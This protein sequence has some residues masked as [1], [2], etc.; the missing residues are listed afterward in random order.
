MKKLFVWPFQIYT[1]LFL[2]PYVALSTL[3]FGTLATILVFIIG[4]KRASFIGGVIWARLIGYLT[5]L[6]VKVVGRENV[7]PK[8]SY[9]IITNHQSIYDIIVLY[10]WLGL[11]FRWVMKM[12]LRKVPALGIAC[13]KIGHIF[14]DRS[15]SK[16]AVESINIAKKR[17]VN[18]TSVLFFPEGT[19]SLTGELRPFK[20]GAFNIAMDL[21]I[22][23]LPI[24]IVG[25]RNIIPSK[26]LFLT[27]GKVKMVFHEPID[28]SQYDATSIRKL[29]KKSKE[30]VG[31]ALN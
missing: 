10:G 20:K 13:E 7:D 14:I 15:N 23:I 3:F 4:P 30:V 2:V 27:P 25:T 19:R 16:K 21:D 28:T 5:P 8:Q 26:S 9:V 11:D 17:V 1:W 22:P 31:S 12:E 29:I 18:G 24:S 6:F